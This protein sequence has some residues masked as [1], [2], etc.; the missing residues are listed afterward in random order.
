MIVVLL[1]VIAGV[2]TPFV[3]AWVAQD[4]RINALEAD[5]AHRERAVQELEV[6]EQRWQD[7]NYVIAQARQRFTYVMPG[8][9]GYVILDTPRVVTDERDPSGAAA[10]AAAGSDQSWVSTLWG[11]VHEA[12][13]APADPAGAKSD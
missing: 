5:I 1:L 4:G 12:G 8:E 3:R 11:S 10:R 13:N 6:A 7:P 9:V 2:L